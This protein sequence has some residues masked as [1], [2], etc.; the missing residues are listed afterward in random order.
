MGAGQTVKPRQHRTQYIKTFDSLKALITNTT[1][2]LFPK[3]R[4]PLL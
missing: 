1:Y 3:N 4:N 2:K